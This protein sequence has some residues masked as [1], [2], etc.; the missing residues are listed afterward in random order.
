MLTWKC[1]SLTPTER[2]YILHPFA[3][4]WCNELSCLLQCEHWGKSGHSCILSL[5]FYLALSIDGLSM[6]WQ[7][8][9]CIDLLLSSSIF[10]FS[11]L[12]LS[13]FLIFRAAVSGF[14]IFVLL[15]LLPFAQY[16]AFLPSYSC[17]NLVSLSLPCLM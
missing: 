9:P 10:S 3:W 8:C 4:E 7:K 12:N 15:D 13:W 17:T 2:W 1:N 11:M 14:Y 6:S 16:L 5:A